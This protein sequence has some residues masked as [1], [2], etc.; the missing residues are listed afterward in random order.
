MSLGGRGRPTRRKTRSAETFQ[1]LMTYCQRKHWDMKE[2]AS[3]EEGRLFLLVAFLAGEPTNSLQ[4][5]RR[6][7][8]SRRRSK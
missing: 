1:D 6:N 2:E 5:G 7:D 8:Y 4:L 3:I